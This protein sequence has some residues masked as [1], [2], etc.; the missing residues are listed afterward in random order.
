LSRSIESAK[1]LGINKIHFIEGY[2]REAELPY[3]KIPFL[4]LTPDTWAIIFR[5][6]WFCGLKTNS[7]SLIEAKVRASTGASKLK[8]IAKNNDSVVF[9]GHG[10]MNRFIAK[11]LLL[12][13]WHNSIP[14]GKKHWEFGVYEYSE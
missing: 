6:L 12:S 7:E 5:I 14:L 1:I 13:G 11:E 2:L 10:F 4:T 8:K 9:I 3:F